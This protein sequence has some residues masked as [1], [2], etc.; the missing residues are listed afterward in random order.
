MSERPTDEQLQDWAEDGSEPDGWRE[1]CAELC[2]S[3]KRNARIVGLMRHY[4]ENNRTA[5]GLFSCV[6]QCLDIL[7]KPNAQ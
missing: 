1:L 2:E 3:R 7:G 5:A 4:V 6:A